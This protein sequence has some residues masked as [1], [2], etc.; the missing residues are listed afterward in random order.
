MLF[1]LV[2]RLAAVLLLVA[3]QPAAPAKAADALPSGRQ[4]WQGRYPRSNASGAER[5]LTRCRLVTRRASRHV[6]RQKIPVVSEPT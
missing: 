3:Q 1:S 2:P 5:N 6:G 4:W